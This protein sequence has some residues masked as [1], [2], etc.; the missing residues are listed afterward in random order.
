M[1]AP[2]IVDRRNTRLLESRQV[3]R[4]FVQDCTVEEV[5]EAHL[6]LDA[7]LVAANRFDPY[8][9]RVD[10]VLP[11]GPARLRLDLVSDS[12]VRVRVDA[13][14]EHCRVADHR[15]T[16]TTRRSSAGLRSCLHSEH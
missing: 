5:D 10:P 3:A 6:L 2:P 12:V 1:K 13:L 7:E 16:L 11:P 4:T 14:G 8:A 9:N 15:L